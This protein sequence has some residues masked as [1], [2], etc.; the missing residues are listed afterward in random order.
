MGKIIVSY[1]DFVG[2]VFDKMGDRVGPYLRRII[3]RYHNFLL[4]IPNKIYKPSEEY[5]LS[6][7][8]HK[9]YVGSRAHINQSVLEK[10][11]QNAEANLKKVN[12]LPACFESWPGI[13]TFTDGNDA[14][15]IFWR[16]FQTETRL[17]A[18]HLIGLR[19]NQDEKVS[20]LLKKLDLPFFITRNLLPV[21]TN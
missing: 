13:Q 11:F 6:P 12:K 4:D 8:I 18:L 2:K 21:Q 7:S 19:E 20:K 16:D 17:E 9:D 5:I 14:Y 15:A 10:T 3:E 1:L